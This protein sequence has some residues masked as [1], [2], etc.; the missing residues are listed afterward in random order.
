[1]PDLKAYVVHDG[2]EQTVIVFARHAATAG[3]TARTRWIPISNASSP[4]IAPR[5]SIGTRPAQ[6]LPLP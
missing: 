1:M 6:C 3:V 5:A 4:A 2:E